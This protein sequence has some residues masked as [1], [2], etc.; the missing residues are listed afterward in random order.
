MVN[1]LLRTTVHILSH[2]FNHFMYLLKTYLHTFNLLILSLHSSHLM[3][4][5]FNRLILSKPY[6]INQTKSLL[7]LMYISCLPKLKMEKLPRFR[8]CITSSSIKYST[9][10][11][12]CLNTLTVS[13][14]PKG[15]SHFVTKALFDLD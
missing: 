14:T 11:P 9:N 4:V 10:Y 6:Q 5:I 15:E 12:L 1:I 3:L 8:Q 13:S 7:I 2:P